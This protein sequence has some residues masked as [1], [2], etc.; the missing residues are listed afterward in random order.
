MPQFLNA[1]HEIRPS[2]LTATACSSHDA[3]MPRETT[4]GRRAIPR[5]RAPDRA[6]AEDAVRALIEALGFDA[7]TP[8]LRDTPGRVVTAFLETLVAGYDTSAAA[9]IG[10][11]FP[12]Q[13]AAPIVSTGIPLSFTCP[14]HL[15]IAQGHVHIAFLP[16][17]LVP[18]LS[19]LFRL[20]DAL[21][22]RLILQEDLT[23]DIVEALR[24]AVRAKAGY[25]SIEARHGCIA[26]ED[27]K[28]RDAII[29]TTASFGTSRNV[30]SL[31]R[32]IDA[33]LGGPWKTSASGAPSPSPASKSRSRSRP[34]SAAARKQ[35]TR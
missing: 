22:R 1:R 19:R 16:G 10:R 17:G 34:R 15:M 20:V 21:S 5:P 13:H 7:E 14:H 11:G 25:V 2:S 9:A 31:R 27:P 33:T 23:Q 28:R 18:G 29:R 4:P 32:E 3:Q 12:R 35:P 24:S 26:V 30:E 6:R 8:E